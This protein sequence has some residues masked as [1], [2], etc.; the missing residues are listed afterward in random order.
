[1]ADEIFG[2][3][4]RFSNLIIWKHDQGGSTAIQTAGISICSRQ[5]KQS[6]KRLSI[7]SLTAAAGIMTPLFMVGQ[8]A[9]T[10]R[11]GRGLRESALITAEEALK[12]FSPQ[13]EYLRQKFDLFP[14]MIYPPLR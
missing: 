4:C 11:R 3:I 6:K 12:L 13:Q 7:T 8:S 2:P 14:D 1:M 10:F 9:L 5:T